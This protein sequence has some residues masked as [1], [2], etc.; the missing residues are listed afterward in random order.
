[1][2]ATHAQWCDATIEPILEPELPIVDAHHHLWVVSETDLAL[3]ESQDNIGARALSPVY[4]RHSRYLL[5]EYLSDLRTGHN[6][7]ASIFV[8]AH[9]MYRSHGPEAMKSVG[10]VEFVNGI[11]AMADSG[12]FGDTKVCAG[13]VGGVDLTIGPAVEEVLLAHM[14]AGGIRYRGIRGS[15]LVYDED[16]NILGAR[17]RPHLL[18]DPTFRASFRLLQR[19]GLSFDV[20][21]FEPQ[22]PELID[23]ARTFPETQ[24]ILN[25]VG[26]PI[27]VGCYA[28]RREE[29][30]V[31]W[32]KSI[33]SLA[34]CHNVAVKLGGLGIPYGGFRSYKAI[35]TATS[36]QLAAEWR[37]YIET[38]IEQF[39]AERCMFESNF[40]VDSATCSYPVLWNAFKRLTAGASKAEKTALFSGT[41]TR[42]YRLDL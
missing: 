36:A 10:E 40:P 27:G 35:P 31:D 24:I 5:D 29:R 9:T 2:V 12:M 41:A 32:R 37:P 39:G 16:P 28:G 8:D 4:R 34:G 18:L 13:I 22:L 33:E 17:G 14:Q 26:A 23:L 6:V 25:H 1:M 38:C 3:M 30:F 42:I 7:R 20:F 11:A 19:F 15:R 21:L